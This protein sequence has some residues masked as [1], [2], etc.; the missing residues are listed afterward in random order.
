MTWSIVHFIV[1]NTVEIVPSQ[2]IK[3]NGYCSWPKTLK[4]ND[5]RKLVQ[6]KVRSNKFD[7]NLFKA[8]CL[9]GDIGKNNNYYLPTLFY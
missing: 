3:R 8:R 2:W 6:N 7:F 5:V 9:A 1:D 4:N